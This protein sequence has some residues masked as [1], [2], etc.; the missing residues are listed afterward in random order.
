MGGFPVVNGFDDSWRASPS[1]QTKVCLQDRASM[2]VAQH[3]SRE[4]QLLCGLMLG[5]IADVLPA[6]SRFA[7]EFEQGTAVS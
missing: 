3:R 4:M 5:G 7:W 2:M 1:I 6:L